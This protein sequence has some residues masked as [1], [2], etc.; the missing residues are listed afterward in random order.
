MNEL[1]KIPHQKLVSSF[2]SASIRHLAWALLSPPLF[3]ETLQNYSTAAL[4]PEREQLIKWLAKQD[5]QIEDGGF[6]NK[7]DP[8][9]FKR[10]GI[11]FEALVAFF[12][13]QALREGVISFE[14]IARNLQIIEEN[15]TLGEIDFLIKHG[16]QAMHLE[17]AVKF[18]LLSDQVSSQDRHKWSSWIG[19]NANDR[20]DLKLNKMLTHQLTLSQMPQCMEVIEQKWPNLGKIHANYLMKGRFYSPLSSDE[21]I[22]P[23]KANPACEKGYWVRISKFLLLLE[24]KSLRWLPLEKLSWMAGVSRTD[25]LHSAMEGTEVNALMQ[26]SPVAG[27]YYFGQLPLQFM[28]FD[29]SESFL[30]PRFLMVVEDH[31]PTA[32]CPS[33]K[34]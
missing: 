17:T 31:W 13:E 15:K 4:Y 19:A 16:R 12:M 27:Q 23:E 9:K 25:F 5:E 1:A 3:I 14:L 22:L 2:K 34:I 24:D 26:Q 33:R 28:Y 18:Y 32:K 8:T 30:D 29:L 21:T 10:I 6:L 7:I 11:Y 20:L